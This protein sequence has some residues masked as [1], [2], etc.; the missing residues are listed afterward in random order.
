LNVTGPLGYRYQMAIVDKVPGLPQPV[1]LR[2]NDRP[3]AVPEVG[4]RLKISCFNVEN[5]FNGPPLG[6]PFGDRKARGAQDGFEFGRQRA[7]THSAMAALDAAV[8]AL[9]EVENNGDAPGSAV[10]D[11]VKGLNQAAG[12]AKYIAVNMW[13]KKIGTDVISSNFIYQP[14]LVKLIGVPAILDSSVDPLFLDSK[15]RPS[16]AVSFEEVATGNQFTIAANH[17][18]S[19]GSSCISCCGDPEIP[20][21]GNCNGVRTNA[22]RALGRWL[23]TNPTG[24]ATDD[25]LITGDMNAYHAESPIQALINDFGYVDMVDRFGSKTKAYSYVFRG[26]SGYLDHALASPSLASKITKVMDWHINADESSAFEYGTGYK[27]PKQIEE[28]YTTE[29]FRCSDHDP[30]LLGLY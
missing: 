23:Q 7:K 4:G 9:S 13:G 2:I 11:L 22:T 3:E 5:Y 16:V 20:G 30:L 24:I 17:L 18:K 14:S 10:Q 15:N 29:P 21:V 19:K 12:S 1:H 26:Q 6:L 27:S 28:Y 8:F 25:V